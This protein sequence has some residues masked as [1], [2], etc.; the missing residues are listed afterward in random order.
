MKNKYDIIVVGAGPA[1][2]TAAKFAAENGADV[3]I[4]DRR[5]ELGV[6]VQCGEA[7]SEEVLMDLNIDPDPRWA[8]NKIDRVK[9][10]SPSGKSVG[11]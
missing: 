5:N 8:L 11:Y 7:L 1:G 3:L 2:S 10:V 9:L 6:P 4:L